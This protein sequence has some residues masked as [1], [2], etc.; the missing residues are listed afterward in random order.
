MA[1]RLVHLGIG[2]SDAAG[3]GELL[4]LVAT[5]LA[6]LTEAGPVEVAALA[7]IEARRNHPAVSALGAHLRMPVTVY[8]AAVLEAETPRLLNPSETVFLRTG[9]HGVA[10]AAALASAGV[11]GR[12][13]LGKIKSACATVA[14]ACKDELF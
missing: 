12:L 11:Q 1:P 7:T 6:R 5:A 13:V 4:S 2:V 8:S 10:E 14:A 3:S 9:C